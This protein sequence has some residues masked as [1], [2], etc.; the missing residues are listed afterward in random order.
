MSRPQSEV[1]FCQDTKSFSTY[2]NARVLTWE[3]R[4]DRDGEECTFL[5]ALGDQRGLSVLSSVVH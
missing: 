3:G 2:P 1:A 5:L 4:S